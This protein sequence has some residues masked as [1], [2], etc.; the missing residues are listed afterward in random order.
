MNI[1]ARDDRKKG[2]GRVLASALPAAGMTLGLFLVMDQLVRVGEIELKAPERRVLASITPERKPSDPPRSDREQPVF[3]DV[4]P[5][6]ANV[7][8]GK[9]DAQTIP[10]APPVLSAPQ[11]DIPAGVL[12]PIR[13][14]VRVIERERAIPVRN[15]IPDYPTRALS[16]ELEG[17]CEVAFSI[18][19]AGRPYDIN[20]TCT[21]DVF[22]RSSINAVERALFAARTKNGVPAGQENLVYPIQFTLN[23]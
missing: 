7:P 3:I 12:E 10:F 4:A 18:D 11:A 6:P 8:V 13:T 22:A 15:P 21:D 14:A 23:D 9:P 2:A 16:R 20:A 17:E 5:P 19:A 1:V